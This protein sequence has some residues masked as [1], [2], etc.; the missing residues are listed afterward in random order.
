MEWDM[1]RG[2]QVPTSQESLHEKSVRIALDYLARTNEIDD[3]DKA[4]EFLGRH[5]AKQMA[6]GET[7]S[8][9]LSNKAIIAFQHQKPSPQLHLVD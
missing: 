4:S 6:N 5:I 1:P 3:P 9:V 8:L 2:A 7:S